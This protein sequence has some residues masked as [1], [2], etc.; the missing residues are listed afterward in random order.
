MVVIE[1]QPTIAKQE[2]RSTLIV[3]LIALVE[4]WQKKC[5]G[6]SHTPAKALAYCTP[7]NV[8]GRELDVRGLKAMHAQ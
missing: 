5:V 6:C 4:W 7:D 1:I 8:S 2:T 3:T